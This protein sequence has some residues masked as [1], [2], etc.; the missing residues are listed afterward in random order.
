MTV[1]RPGDNVVPTVMPVSF[2]RLTPPRS[3]NRLILMPRDK[4]YSAAAAPNSRQISDLNTR[5]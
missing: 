3:R 2:L 4:S 1:T 5:M